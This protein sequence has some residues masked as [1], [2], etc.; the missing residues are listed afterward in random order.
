MRTHPLPD[1]VNNAGSQGAGPSQPRRGAAPPAVV[2]GFCHRCGR[3]GH[4]RTTC[5]ANTDVDG[6][7]IVDGQLKYAPS[8]GAN[9][10]PR[11][12]GPSA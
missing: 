5:Y 2:T 12:P 9:K 4:W 11:G 6:Q 10:K 7:A 1:A 3:Q 8:G